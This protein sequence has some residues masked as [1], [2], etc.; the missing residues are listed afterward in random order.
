[1]CQMPLTW[2]RL[3]DTQGANE[4]FCYKVSASGLKA[5]IYI[6]INQN[7]NNNNNSW[8]W[9]H[10]VVFLGRMATFEA[11]SFVFFSFSF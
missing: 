10:F 7:N 2:W 8:L 4:N 1:M 9:S 3:S 6:A 5:C 11:Y